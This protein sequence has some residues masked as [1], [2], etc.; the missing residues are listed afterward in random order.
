MSAM[1]IEDSGNPNKQKL[2]VKTQ[3]SRAANNKGK[4]ENQ[5]RRYRNADKNNSRDAKPSKPGVERD[6]ATHTDERATTQHIAAATAR[7]T[8]K[9]RRSSRTMREHAPSAETTHTLA[10]AGNRC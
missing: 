10:T 9:P 2:T 8:E 1:S 3:A 5:R 6:S 4:H 7:D